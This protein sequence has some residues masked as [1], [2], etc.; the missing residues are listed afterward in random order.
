MKKLTAL[1]I[2]SIALVACKKDT[3]TVT[4]ID[5]ETGKEITVEVPAT[6]STTVENS[7]A[8]IVEGPA[9][10]ENNGLYTQ[11]FKLEKGQTYPLTT[12]QK[13]VQTMTGPDGKSM[14]GT[15]QSTDEMTFTVNDYKDGVYDITINLLGKSNSQTANG[16]TVSVSTSSGEPKDEN[17]KMMWKINKALVGNKLQ[18]KMKS[19]G[20]VASIKGFEPIYTKVS[21]AA[22][23]MIK[24][25]TQRDE[26][27]K[28][29][30]ES[31]NENTIKEQF[32]KNLLILPK[33][34]AKVGQKWTETENASPDG[35]V[36]L[37]TSY[38]LTSVKNG[39][40]K[41]AVSG[42]IPKKTDKQTQEGVTRS[43]TS[44]LSQNGTVTLDQNTG[45]IKNQ[46][47]TVKSNQTETLSDGKQSQ[48]VKSSSTATVTVNPQK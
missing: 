2:L 6:D 43:L 32:T 35:S 33:A 12:H 45:W 24:D 28:G 40:A 25:A 23:S 20:E 29:F 8:T 46:T 7:A 5:P 27:V 47:V 16:Q 21:T 4:K 34:G 48:S 38:T 18:M 42:G 9:I 19:N 31:F 17:L 36:K 22:S 41:I 13:N 14:T 15:S 11:S 44:E 30:K 1:A 37:T 39:V 26:F 3:K 10:Q